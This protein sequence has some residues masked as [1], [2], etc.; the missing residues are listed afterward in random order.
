MNIEIC[1]I[2]VS[3]F[4]VQVFNIL[5]IL[6][7]LVSIEVIF[8]IQLSFNLEG[9]VVFLFFFKFNRFMLHFLKCFLNV[10]NHIL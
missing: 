10:D 9:Y 5:I 1:G 4:D 8:H 6:K 2:Y 7:A 3:K